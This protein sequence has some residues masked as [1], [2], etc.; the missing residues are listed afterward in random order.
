MFLLAEKMHEIVI[1]MDEDGLIGIE[2][3]LPWRIPE[4]L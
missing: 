1:A 4:E 3:K 2:N